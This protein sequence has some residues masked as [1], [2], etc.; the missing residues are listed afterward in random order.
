MK[1]LLV[2]VVGW[3]GVLS[4]AEPPSPLVA[5]PDYTVKGSNPLKLVPYD[6]LLELQAVARREYNTFVLDRYTVRKYPNAVYREEVKSLIRDARGNKV[7]ELTNDK[8]IDALSPA[9]AG[10]FASSN[11][12]D[13]QAALYFLLQTRRTPDET[14]LG[15]AEDLLREYGEFIAARL[16]FAQQHY[17]VK[18]K[19]EFRDLYE[20]T[21]PDEIVV[22]AT[23][24]EA[25]RRIAGKWGGSAVGRTVGFS[26]EQLGAARRKAGRDTLLAE[27]PG[28]ID[29]I[30]PWR[31]GETA[32][33]VQN[34]AAL[35]MIGFAEY[36]AHFFSPPRFDVV[37]PALRN[38]PPREK[39]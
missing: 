13:D 25:A 23:S 30:A 36:R 20:V 16:A 18:R 27:R 31:R 4:G 10:L 24:D 29:C 8:G 37:L 32:P 2:L 22:V 14:T 38:P 35:L 21:V 5:L 33:I 7:K 28:D 26:K 12:P 6:Q 39:P 34:H 9:F 3:V 1:L 19:E 17:A 11:Q 15:F